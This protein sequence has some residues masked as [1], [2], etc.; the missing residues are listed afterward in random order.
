MSK[1]TIKGFLYHVKYAW[2]SDVPFRVCFADT[3]TMGK[4]SNG[5]WTLIKPHE[6]VVEIPDDFDPRPAKI[7][8]LRELKQDV[9]AEFSKRV[10]EIDKQIQKLL[11]L[12]NHG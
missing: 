6:F 12:E 4:S 7:T 9:Q 3:D 2:Q 10:L 1:H 11:A 8:A 5:A